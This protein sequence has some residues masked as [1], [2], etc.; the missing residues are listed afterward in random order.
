MIDIQHLKVSIEQKEILKDISLSIPAST[1]TSIIGSNG[2]GKSTLFKAI[3]GQ[4]SIQGS[5][6]IDH[7]KLDKT[8][9]NSI[10][11]KIGY[12]SFI[13][14]TNF[15]SETVKSELSYALYNIGFPKEKIDQ[16]RRK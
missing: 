9:R 6:V 11:K 12:V 14:E 13:T 2:S 4:I 8:T 3:L 7:I 5:I 15:L 1:F 10:L 16:K